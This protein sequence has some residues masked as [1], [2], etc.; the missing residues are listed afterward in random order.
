MF[1]SCR[2]G[3]MF[4][5]KKIIIAISVICACVATC[6]IIFL[7][8]PST[9]KH[10]QT[11]ILASYSH[12]TF[13]SNYKTQP[14]KAL[15]TYTLELLA[16]N[17]TPFENPAITSSTNITKTIQL[18]DT[19]IS[20]TFQILF[21]NQFSFTLTTSNFETF[22]TTKTAT[23]YVQPDTI[24]LRIAKEAN[25]EELGFADNSTNVLYLV[26]DSY[27]TLA[28]QGGHASTLYLKVYAPATCTNVTFDA[29]ISASSHFMMTTNQ[30]LIS[31]TAES[32]G[33]SYITFTANDGSGAS[34]KFLF[35][36]KYVPATSLSGLPDEINVNLS[37][38]IYFT[39]PTLSPVPIYAQNYQLDFESTNSEIFT[40]SGTKITAVKSGSANLIV[41]IDGEVF[42]TIPVLISGNILPQF[43]FSLNQSTTTALGN[44]INFNTQTN[45]ITLDFS[46]LE[47]TYSTIIIDVAFLYYD[48]QPLP[49]TVDITD[50]NSAILGT[51][52]FTVGNENSVPYKLNI[53]HTAS[54]IEINFSK[55]IYENLISSKIKIKLINN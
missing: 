47:N 30:D 2:F 7:G 27:K 21:G 8:Q 28:L 13:Y 51:P 11:E 1:L 55:T 23:E 52:E 22:T 54:E 50:A 24:S 15:N 40:I 48:G 19:S 44:A 34:K 31:I 38:S 29:T 12:E 3:I 4:I 39:L 26:E 49:I 17:G 5:M 35:H 36:T 9:P 18:T 32:L 45:T 46:S 41:K 43:S 6:L 20:I 53:S 10:P 16:L 14:E 37:E 42:K 33:S 25:G